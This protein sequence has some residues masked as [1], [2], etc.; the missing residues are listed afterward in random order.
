MKF[1]EILQYLS[2]ITILIA[3]F[4]Y[5]S[6]SLS[7]FFG[8]LAL[9]DIIGFVLWTF[10]SISGQSSW[11][12]I[13]YLILFSTNKSFIKKWKIYI[14]FGL[15]LILLLNQYS[16]VKIQQ[17]FVL[18]INV[19]IMFLFLRLLITEFV[20]KDEFRIL[21]LILTLYQL[22]IIFN[23]MA[24]IRDLKIGL[25]IYFAGII[26]IILI[27]IFLIVLKEDAF[28]NIKKIYKS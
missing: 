18:M 3:A 14:L 15:I 24:F 19:I 8:L 17:Y 1:F 16:T 26:G 2:L 10:F 25:D 27:H 5:R 23:L 22:L 9:N 7:I 21:Y 13:F 20:Q 11:I 12:P 6:S 28:I 4:K